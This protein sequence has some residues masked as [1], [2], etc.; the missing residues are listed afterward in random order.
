MPKT[1]FLQIRLTP[2]DLDRIRRVAKA[3]HLETSTWA[4][5]VLLKEV[6]KWEE[7]RTLE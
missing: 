5:R 3:E 4:R 6:E 2:E 7:R 1:E